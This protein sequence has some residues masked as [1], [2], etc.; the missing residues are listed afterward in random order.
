MKYLITAVVMALGFIFLPWWGVFVLGIVSLIYT[1]GHIALLFMI[2]LDF[3]ALPQEFP[4]ASGI[5][6]VCMVLAH[7]I[8]DRMFDG[9]E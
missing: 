7:V 8:K 9:V 3:L 5:F 1:Q 6:L 2:L 4:Y